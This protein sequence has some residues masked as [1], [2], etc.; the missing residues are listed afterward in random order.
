MKK[1]LHNL[2][3]PGGE[4]GE[5]F[6]EG[7]RF[8]APG[9]AEDV[10]LG[11]AAALPAFIDSHCHILPTGLDLMKLSLQGCADQA[12]VLD[13]VRDHCRERPDLPW[14]MAVRYDQ[15]RFPDG[16]HLTR[17]DLDA[18]DA[19]RPILLRHVNGHAS[20]A[21]S[22]ALRAAGVDGSTPDPAGGEYRRGP[23]GEPDGVLLERAH[24]HVTGCAPAPTTEQMVEAILRAAKSMSSFGIASGTDMMTGRWN[25]AQELEA[26]RLA[27]ER[28]CPIRLRLCLQWAAVL[29]P[30]GIDAARL[31]ELTGAMNPSAC[32]VIGLK[33]FSDGAIG[34]ATAAIH[35]RYAA[36]GQ[37]RLIYAPERLS[38]MIREGAEAGWRIIVHAIG[39]R[40]VDH[41]L[42][43]FEQT[44]EPS[45]N[46][47]EHAMILSDAQI[48]RIAK[49]GCT[50]T[51]QP[52]FLHW[53]GHSYRRQLGEEAA[54]RLNRTASLLK[55]G[56]PVAFN[57]DRPIVDGNPWTGI[58]AAVERN[59]FDGGES[60]PIQE[61]FRL[62]AEGGARADGDVGGSFEPGSPA[63]LQLYADSPW[64]GSSA[65]IQVWRNG[66]PV[67]L[68][69]GRERGQ[70]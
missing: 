61:A 28:G 49:T 29:G 62:Y 44:P 5:L 39:D 38:G 54:A 31:K 60:V 27:S 56:I 64:D 63:D 7:G 36:G 23:D 33:I 51:Q 25:L 35:G 57:S 37:G 22:A 48:E 18:V 14:V 52:E 53:F 1:R 26:Y 16:A 21:N 10:D 47:L 45:R 12:S 42:D 11:G 9:P 68:E 30:R 70:A 67:E 2:L 55:A 13:A 15:T 59:G 4:P 69:S 43:G 58:R 19:E 50:V 17:S 20:V 24:E 41:V 8:A 6:I 66:T 65:P 40:A 46:R 34:S 32:R 3:L